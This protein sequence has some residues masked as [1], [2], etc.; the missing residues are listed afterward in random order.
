[1]LYNV[2]AAGG[3]DL[4]LLLVVLPVKPPVQGSCQYLVASAADILSTDGRHH[5]SCA[6]G[7]LLDG[8]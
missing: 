4:E 5:D 2:Y 3:A 1:M 8:R 6:G 7:R